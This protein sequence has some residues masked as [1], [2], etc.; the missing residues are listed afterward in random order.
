MPDEIGY[1]IAEFIS[2]QKCPFLTMEANT[3]EV[4]TAAKGRKTVTTK[5]KKY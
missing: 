2:N 4:K 1:L 5:K 3:K